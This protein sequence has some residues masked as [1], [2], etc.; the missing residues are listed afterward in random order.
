MG[1]TNHTKSSD[2]QPLACSQEEEEANELDEQTDQ[3]IQSGS[4]TMTKAKLGH[5]QISEGE[6]LYPDHHRSGGGSLYPAPA[7]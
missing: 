3:I 2:S 1:Q 6:Y 5:Y 7:E 4:V